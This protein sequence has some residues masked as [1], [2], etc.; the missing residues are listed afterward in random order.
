MHKEYRVFDDPYMQL[1][2]NEK[3]KI[4]KEL[5]EAR[6]ED[7]DKLIDAQISKFTPEEVDTLTSESEEESA[8]SR[9]N[10]SPSIVKDSSFYKR[11]CNM[12][13]R[14]DVYKNV[15]YTKTSY[16]EREHA[17]RLDLMRRSTERI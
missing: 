1:F 10:V 9:N 12:N 5:R 4:S 7:L 16:M 15:F 13:E 8:F 6:P 11:L 2:G 17:R 14:L 3:L